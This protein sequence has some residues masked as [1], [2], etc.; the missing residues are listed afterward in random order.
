DPPVGWLV[1]LGPGG[2]MTELLRDTVHLLAPVTIDD[3]RTALTKLRTY[4]VLDGFRGRAPADIDPLAT[5]V[6]RLA[7]AVVG[8]TSAVEVELNPVLVGRDGAVA[9]D[10]LWIETETEIE[11]EEQEDKER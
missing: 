5:L 2:V 4:P 7:D 8:D 9:V 10:A 11:I 6:V 3:V 1:T